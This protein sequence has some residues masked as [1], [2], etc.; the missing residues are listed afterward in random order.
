MTRGYYFKIFIQIAFGFGLYYL[1]TTFIEN[2]AIVLGILLA[3]VIAFLIYG[4]LTQKNPADV[5]EVVCDYDKFLKSIDKNREQENMYSLLMAYGYVHNGKFEEA[6]SL[7]D[8]I[9]YETLLHDKRFNFINTVVTLKL[10]FEN[11]DRDLYGKL[12][13]EA[14]E[15]EVFSKVE[16]SN[17]V[18][19]VHF[20]ILDGN[21]DKAELMIKDAIPQLKTRLYI[22]EL[23]YLLALSYL[24]QDKKEDCKAV[25]E[26]L[27]MKDYNIIYTKLCKDINDTLEEA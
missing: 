18:F 22:L 7:L 17:D 5:L 8:G 9:K 14:I 16:M 23:E 24:K 15:N 2:N 12:F 4:I 1:L 3:I 25:C 26:F 27:I 10:A 13:T 21:Y 20:L 19:R 6:Q 11:N